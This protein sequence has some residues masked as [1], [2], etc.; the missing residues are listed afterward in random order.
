MTGDSTGLRWPIAGL[1]FAPG[2]VI[3]TSNEVAEP[4]VRLRFAGPGMLVLLPRA[5]LDAA[6]TALLPDGSRATPR[7]RGG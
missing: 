7:V 5:R 2:G 1:D 3:G 6:L 4:E